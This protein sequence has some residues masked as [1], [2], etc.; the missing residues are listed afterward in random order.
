M[1]RKVA[2]KKKEQISPVEAETKKCRLKRFILS[3]FKMKGGNFPF[4]KNVFHSPTLPHLSYFSGSG[5]SKFLT[6][7]KAC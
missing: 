5:I 3:Y 7:D 1:K 2:A 6:S 4:G